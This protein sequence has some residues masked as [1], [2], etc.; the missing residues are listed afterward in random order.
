VR[1]H[2]LPL[3]AFLVSTATALAECRTHHHLFVTAPNLAASYVVIVDPAT[4]ATDLVEI[5]RAADSWQALV[6]GLTVDIVRGSCGVVQPPHEIC[7][8]LTTAEPLE[9]M[10][11]ACPKGSLGC[12]Q[13]F[14]DDSSMTRVLWTLRGDDMFRVAAH[15]MGHAFGLKE[16]GKPG[17]IMAAHL[18]QQPTSGVTCEDARRFWAVRGLAGGCQ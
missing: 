7:F 17:E 16:H 2:L 12:T 15:E 10:G 3:F 14:E 1:Y 9:A 18:E 6:M 5:R 11:V 8:L 4:T 13:H